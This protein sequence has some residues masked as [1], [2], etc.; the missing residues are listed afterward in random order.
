MPAEKHL[1]NLHRAPPTQPQLTL[2][3]CACDMEG[4][5]LCLVMT[6]LQPLCIVCIVLL[7]TFGG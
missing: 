7:I 1:A 2:N 4:I 6:Y 5:Q 3:L